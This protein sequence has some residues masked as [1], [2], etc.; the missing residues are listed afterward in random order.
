[1]ADRYNKYSENNLLFLEEDSKK[2]A[3]VSDKLLGEALS[4]KERTKYDASQEQ[5]YRRTYR[6]FVDSDKAV[7]DYIEASEKNKDK[8]QY[9]KL[10]GK[11]DPAF[12]K[13]NI[14]RTASNI[15]TDLRSG[16]IWF[17]MFF[18]S[19]FALYS[20]FSVYNSLDDE[21][22]VEFA[23]SGYKKPYD[24]NLARGDFKFLN[25]KVDSEAK[26][27]LFELF[28]L[29]NP[30]PVSQEA[31]TRVASSLSGLNITNSSQSLIEGVQV[32][33]DSLAVSDKG[34]G[35]DENYAKQVARESYEK[36]V[37][38]I[39]SLL[40]ASQ[41]SSTVLALN[42]TEEPRQTL[43]SNVEPEQIKP[44][45]RKINEKI[46]IIAKPESAEAPKQAPRQSMF[47]KKVWQVQVYSASSMGEARKKW[48]D[49]QKIT[50]ELFLD[51]K[52]H[53]LEANVEGKMYY[54]LRI[55]YVHSDDGGKG[56]FETKS[57]AVN[58][59]NLLRDEGVDCYPTLTDFKV[60][61]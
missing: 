19:L 14:K 44:E 28:K 31:S 17:I 16:I 47:D 33:S 15:A 38:D 53:I 26:S 4:N 12:S 60:L 6:S 9:Q 57:Q 48:L 3:E 59:C 56:Y 24:G 51:Q 5:S 55:G 34:M 50:P 35:R 10:F 20:V 32:Q 21:S 2:E 18:A 8:A 36:E 39:K 41:D 29:K 37:K 30:E 22:V 13:T 40:E 11:K 43:V 52:S 54:R 46:E 49:L 45:A 27:K 7:E 25:K 61:N 23:G 42:K 58:F 1:M